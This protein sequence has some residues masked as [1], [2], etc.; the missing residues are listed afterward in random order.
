M[1]FHGAYVRSTCGPPVPDAQVDGLAALLAGRPV[2]V[3]LTSRGAFVP[4]GQGGKVAPT[5]TDL[6]QAAVALARRNIRSLL[7]RSSVAAEVSAAL[8]LALTAA[9]QDT[10]DALED[11]QID[12][13]LRYSL[14]ATP[15]ARLEIENRNLVITDGGESTVHIPR[16][17]LRSAGETYFCKPALD[18]L[19]GM[20]VAEV[21]FA[22]T[23]VLPIW[24]QLEPG[25]IMAPDTAH[26]HLHKGNRPSIRK[27]DFI[28]EYCVACGRC[29]I[30][31]PDN[32]IIHARVDEGARDTTGVLGIDT[33]RCTACGLCSAVCP[34]NGH[35]Y[36]AIV[37]IEADAESTP[38]M[39]C[40][41]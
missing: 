29:F 38:E 21:R 28:K 1:M 12:F 30:H 31:C 15:D 18:R 9:P 6:R 36:K 11:A 26:L 35:G 4:P 39:H 27:A 24:M 32:A 20:D 2:E 14:F 8:K 41:G 7:S 10:E 23:A 22:P 25:A 17:R 13:N 33:D 16:Q 3:L 40:M 34:A 19:T 5:R 37:M